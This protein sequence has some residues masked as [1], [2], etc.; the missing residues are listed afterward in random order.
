MRRAGIETKHDTSAGV[1][2][3]LALTLRT[4][5]RAIGAFSHSHQ[6]VRFS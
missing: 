3:I 5:Q 1:A 2:E 4:L 6:H